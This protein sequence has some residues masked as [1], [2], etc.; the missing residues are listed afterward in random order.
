MGQ[1]GRSNEGKPFRMEGLFAVVLPLGGG[2]E[3]VVLDRLDA[4]RGTLI[5]GLA[6]G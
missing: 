4:R 5:V 1:T 2:S 3:Q 6:V